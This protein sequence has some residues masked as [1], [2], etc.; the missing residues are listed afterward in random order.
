M[1]TDT[2]ASEMAIGLALCHWRVKVDAN[3]VEFVLGSSPSILNFNLS[4][5]HIGF[6]RKSI[7]IGSEYLHANFRKRVPHLWM[8]DYDKCQKLSLTDEGIEQAV[9]AV[10]RNDPYF[11][12]PYKTRP[13]DQK[14]WAHFRKAYLDASR[15]IMDADGPLG[16]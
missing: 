9:K 5:Q 10:E 14:L 4:P 2:I 8:L 6:M 1:E 16:R 3:D 11:P 7:N 12:K 13:G 15:T